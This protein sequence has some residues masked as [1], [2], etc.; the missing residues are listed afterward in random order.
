MLPE[1]RNRKQNE[2]RERSLQVSHIQETRRDY[3]FHTYKKRGERKNNNIEDEEEL[4]DCRDFFN[5]FNEK[6]LT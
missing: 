2:K 5:S 1:T 4:E 6:D 3:R